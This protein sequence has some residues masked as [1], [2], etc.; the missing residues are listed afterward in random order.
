MEDLH[1]KRLSFAQDFECTDHHAE[2]QIGKLLHVCD[3]VFNLQRMA[4]ER[5][6]K[7]R[8][9]EWDVK[10]LMQERNEWRRIPIYPTPLNNLHL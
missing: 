10:R 3:K 9:L 6:I 1:S 8:D 2:F 5:I 7:Q 4:E